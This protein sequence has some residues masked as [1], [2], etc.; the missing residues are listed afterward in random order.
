MELKVFSNYIISQVLL[1][2]IW[3][4]NIFQIKCPHSPVEE[5][6]P[7]RGNKWYPSVGQSAPPDLTHVK[8]EI[9]FSS[10]NTSFLILKFFNFFVD[11]I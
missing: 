2:D 6:V 11:T 8:V 1:L 5:V 4:L 3:K 7:V 9:F 10:L